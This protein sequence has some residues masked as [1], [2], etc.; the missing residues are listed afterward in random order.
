MIIKQIYNN[1]VI[2]SENEAGDE[3]ILVGRGIAFGM[4]RGSKVVEGR[5][6]KKFELQDDVGQ[7][8]KT[9]VQDVPYKNNSGFGRNYRLYQDPVHQTDQRFH[10]CHAHRSH[11]Q[12]DRTDQNG[13][14]LRSDA[15]A[16]RQV[17]V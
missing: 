11:C 12:Y 8:F 17:A 13:D 2:L 15:A 16:Q 6:E 5:I 7:K 14:R 1:N 3:I 9:L 4:T 10:L